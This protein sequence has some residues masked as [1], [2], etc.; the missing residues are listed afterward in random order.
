MTGYSAAVL[1]DTTGQLPPRR[2]YLFITV[3]D[4]PVICIGAEVTATVRQTRQ[5]LT[6]FAARLLTPGPRFGCGL[7]GGLLLLSTRMGSFPA[8]FEQP[9]SLRV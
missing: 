5:P 4:P 3:V 6:P 7:L 8:G 1:T 2:P 9:A